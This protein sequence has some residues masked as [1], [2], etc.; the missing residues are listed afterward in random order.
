MVSTSHTAK[1]RFFVDRW[2]HL[3][4]CLFSSCLV[5]FWNRCLNT[6]LFHLFYRAMHIKSKRNSIVSFSSHGM[7]SH[8]VGKYISLIDFRNYRYFVTFTAYLFY[9]QNWTFITYGD[10]LFQID[11]LFF[12]FDKNCHRFVSY[13]KAAI[14]LAILK[15]IFD[16]VLFLFSL[17]KTLFL[18]EVVDVI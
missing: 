18:L 15:G 7:L 3:P 14:F 5:Y 1:L 10:V 17:L 12:K 2:Q 8:P 13:E 9:M 4:K 6:K 16:I 11:I